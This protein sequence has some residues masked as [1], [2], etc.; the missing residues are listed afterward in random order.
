MWRAHQQIHQFNKVLV[1]LEQDLLAIYRGAVSCGRLVDSPVLAELHELIDADPLLA[2]QMTRIKSGHAMTPRHAMN[3]L[4]LARA[5]AVRAHKLGARLNDF[6]LAALL[7]DL[8]HWRPA[9]LVYVFGPFTREEALT[10]RG[11]VTPA[12]EAFLRLDP[13]ILR[14]IAQHHE[15][16]D[17]KGYP[18]AT[19]SPEPLA[20]L[21]RVVDCYD[22]LCTA[23]RFRPAYTPAR[24]MRSPS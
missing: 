17:G 4:V 24:A 14:W 11:H 23:R 20:Q 3:V 21:I 2:I 15:Q 19:N 5:W 16:P 12:D 1:R 6:C 8:G 18:G 9:S 13:D 10:M 22:G 7:H